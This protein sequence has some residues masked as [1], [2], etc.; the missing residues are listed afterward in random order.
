MIEIIYFSPTGNS[1]F[2]AE[3]LREHLGEG[4]TAIDALEKLDPSEQKSADHKVILFSI[5]GFNP[6]R[7]VNH[8]VKDLP[9]NLCEKISLIAVGCAESWVNDAATSGLRTILEKKGYTIAADQV[10]AMPLTFIMSFPQEAGEKLV[11]DAD[12]KMRA[13]ASL[14]LEGGRS[15]K[16]ISRKSRILNRIGKLEDPASRLFGLELHANR[17][18]TSCGLCGKRCPVG[19]IRFNGKNKPR[20]GFNC[21]MCLRCVYSCPETA[22]SPWTARFIPVKGG[23]D[24]SRYSSIEKINQ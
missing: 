17:N 24:L 14:I 2:V 5:H 11:Y 19:N 16:E 9:G 4:E 6:P 8:F 21:M 23:Y 7:I 20:F 10:I 12:E 15:E 18:C 1:R 3:K 22:I 13:L